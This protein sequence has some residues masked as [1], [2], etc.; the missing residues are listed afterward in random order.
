MKRILLFAGL[1]VCLLMAGAQA[2]AQAQKTPDAQSREVL[3]YQNPKLSPE[4]RADDL[5]GRLDIDQKAKL[6]TNYSF[7]IPELGIRTYNWW[8]EALHGAARA[9]LATSFPQAIGMAASWDVELLQEVFDI[10]STEQR[11]HFVQGRLNNLDPLY[12]GLTVWTPNINIFRDPRW[13]R[14]QETYGEDPYLTAR[15]GESVV[16]G[17]QGQP[18]D[19]YDKLH[20]CLKHYAVH[21]GLEYERHH[22]DVSD[23]PM[24]DFRET[25]LYAFEQL[26]KKTDVQEVMCAYNS[27][28]GHPCCDNDQLLTKILREEWGYKGLVVSDCSAIR[29]L[30]APPGHQPYPGDPTTAIASAVRSGTDLECGKTYRQMA[31]AIRQGKIDEKEVDVSLRRLL[32]ARFRLGEMDPEESVCWNRVDTALLDCPAHQAVAL[33]MAHESLVL[34]H[35]KGILPLAKE[36]VKYAVIGP[37][38]KDEVYPLGNYEGTPAHVISAYEGIC[39]AV[40]ADNIT[41]NP[42]EADIVIYVGGINPRLEGEE[43]PVDIEGF[44][45]GDRTSIELPRDQRAEITALKDAGKRIVYVNYS[46]SAMALVPET[47]NCEAILQAWYAGEMCGAAIADVLFGDYNPSGRLPVT[48]YASDADL[49]DVRDYRMEG[50]TYRYFYGEPL[51]YFGYGQS[52]TTFR[53]GRPR[54][55]GG[56]LVVKVRN[57]GKRDGDE[58]V[59]LYV[60]KKEDTDGPKMALRGFKRVNIPAGKS[61]RV[62]IPLT[63]ET[64]AAFDGTEGKMT[65]SPGHFTLWCGPSADPKTLKKTRFTLK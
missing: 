16:N 21:S 64:W 39:G 43:M 26:V 20:A 27:V 35:N 62:A 61:V 55:R 24:R 5:L 47:K 19:G 38:A 15:M 41:D 18:Q 30:Y 56:E 65:V 54:V 9:G 42:D 8:S 32:V 60:A 6:M 58:V 45:H 40:G 29:D 48:F 25:Y 33:K 63:D 53:F 10:A 14:G 11:I 49:P 22:F 59:Q 52:Y 57:T 12:R 23:I 7:A 31:D 51:W 3:P 28:F 37:N 36:G 17:L 46:G 2:P 13:G 44:F 50:R 4:E 34:L 1:T